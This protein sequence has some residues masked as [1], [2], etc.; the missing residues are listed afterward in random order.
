M[1]G[2]AWKAQPRIQSFLLWSRVG[3]AKGHDRGSMIIMIIEDTYQGRYRFK[4]NHKWGDPWLSLHA[5]NPVFGEPAYHYH[6]NSPIVT[7][8]VLAYLSRRWGLSSN[9]DTS[10]HSLDFLICSKS[11]AAAVAPRKAEG[12]G[13]WSG[14]SGSAEG[15]PW[16]RITVAQ[17]SNATCDICH[18]LFCSSFPVSENTLVI[19]V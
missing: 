5:S 10:P 15:R 1:P 16:A 13:T 4:S 19:V 14:S 11:R 17:L 9:S 2:T 18:K 12:I 6:P 3:T 8:V 7:D